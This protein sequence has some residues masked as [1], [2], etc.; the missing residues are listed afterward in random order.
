MQ[1]CA[2]NRPGFE[3]TKLFMFNFCLAI[4]TTMK[5]AASNFSA[6][7]SNAPKHPRRSIR[8]DCR[9]P[10]FDSGFFLAQFS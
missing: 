2:A 8:Y 4:C 1:K 3:S 9:G 10:A 5:D 7:P 6:L